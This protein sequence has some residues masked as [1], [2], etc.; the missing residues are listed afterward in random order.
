MPFAAGPRHC[1][2][3]T[4]RP[5]RDARAPLQGGASLS[6]DLRTRQADRAGSSD[7]PAHPPP[8]AHEAGTPLMRNFATLTELIEHNRITR[9]ASP[10]SKA[11][12]MP[13]TCRSPSCYERAVGILYHLQRIGRASRRQADP[14]PRQQRAVH[15]RVLGGDPRR[16][17]AGTGRARHQQRAPHEAAAHRATARARLPLHRAAL[18]RAHRHVRRPGGRDG[19]VRRAARAR[20]PGR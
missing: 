10:T 4:L 5:V 3:E 12:T 6:P 9:A 11:R 16:H 18:A 8:A 17:R 15:R 7:Q 19:A 2:G 13:A 14:V 1:I 20:L